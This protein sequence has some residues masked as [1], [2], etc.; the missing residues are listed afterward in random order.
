MAW[1]RE[2]WGVSLWVCCFLGIASGGGCSGGDSGPEPAD[3]AAA[4]S[5]GSAGASGTLG[6]GG[7]GGSAGSAGSAGTGAGGTSG[8]T[9][10]GIGPEV[11]TPVA[12]D[13]ECI[14][15]A[16]RNCCVELINCNRDQACM[17][18][19]NGSDGEF[20]CIL[21]CVDN[22]VSD[23]GVA[24]DETFARCAN[25]CAIGSTIEPPTNELLA[26][27]ISGEREDGGMGADCYVECF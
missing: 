10:S 7:S 9:D 16:R 11:C 3:D 12:G 20:G 17:R 24:N 19:G 25:A 18:G 26:C 8:S 6:R 1:A 27:L 13:S 15:C 5:G 21:T 22:E 23:G 4:G 2:T 14:A